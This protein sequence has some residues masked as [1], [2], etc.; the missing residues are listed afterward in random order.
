MSDQQQFKITW[1]DAGREPTVAP[2]PEF[3]N[4]IDVLAHS[5]ETNSCRVEL[6]YPAKRCGYYRIECLV[7]GIR[8]AVSTAGRPDDP[9]SAQFN[10]RVP[11]PPATVN[12]EKPRKH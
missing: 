9:R 3:P 7:C 10:C 1:I 11:P 8:I 12:L 5:D 4:G 2:N 6:E